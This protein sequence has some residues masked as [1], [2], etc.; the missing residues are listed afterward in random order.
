MDCLPPACMT[1]EC[2][3]MGEPY[4]PCAC[5]PWQRVRLPR[6]YKRCSQQGPRRA[7]NPRS[8]RSPRRFPRAMLNK[9]TIMGRLCA[10]PE[11]RRTQKGIAVCNARIAVERDY[12]WNPRSRR[13]PR[14]FPRIRAC[15]PPGRSSCGSGAV[16]PGLPCGLFR[17]SR[18]ET[19]D[20][21]QG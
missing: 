12:A 2:A 16:R 15:C 1:S 4:R 21:R 18:K 3:Q 11:L 20:E 14:R 10:A 19:Q 13:S 5:G 9:V 7:W 6:G 8:R 17:S